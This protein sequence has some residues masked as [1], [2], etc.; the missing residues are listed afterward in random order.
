MVIIQ[1][2]ND[3]EGFYSNPGAEKA[4]FLNSLNNTDIYQLQQTVI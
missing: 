1:P 3:H 2:I 4:C